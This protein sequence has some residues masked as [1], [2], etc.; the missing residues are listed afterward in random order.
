MTFS[1][2]ALGQTKKFTTTVSVQVISEDEPLKNEMSEHLTRK[3]RAIKDVVVAGDDVPY[4]YALVVII[5]KFRGGSSGFTYVMNNMVLK[6]ANCAYTVK[7][8]N[9]KSDYKK[10]SALDSLNSMS[11][12]DAPILKEKA[13]E[14][15]ADFD[16]SNLNQDRL[17]FDK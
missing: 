16:T 6:S 10:C 12:F 17:V 13:A 5:T 1:F 4:D 7:T 15:I 8:T 9:E 11:V 2:S 14:I 3:L